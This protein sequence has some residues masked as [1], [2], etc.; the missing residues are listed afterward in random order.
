MIKGFEWSLRSYFYFL[1][2]P[3]IP[4]FF[5]LLDDFNLPIEEK[6]EIYVD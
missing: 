2:L 1:S 5:Y 6:K 4:I 3:N